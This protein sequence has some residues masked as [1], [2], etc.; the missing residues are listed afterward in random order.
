MRDLILNE[1][2][3][4]TEIE[5]WFDERARIDPNMTLDEYGI[6]LLG[7]HFIVIK[8]ANLTY[9]FI[10][11]SYNSNGSIYKLIYKE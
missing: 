11:I 1:T 4:Y 5:I 3:L 2:Y 6:F 10:M 8:E 9:S 7:E